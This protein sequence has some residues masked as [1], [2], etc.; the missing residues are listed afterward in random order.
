[1]I[2]KIKEIKTSRI[3][4]EL[5]KSMSSMIL[6]ETYATVWMMVGHRTVGNYYKGSGE[7]TFD[8]QNFMV[9]CKIEY[10]REVYDLLE[11]LLRTKLYELLKNQQIRRIKFI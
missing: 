10:S 1:M 8:I 11:E 5:F 4:A 7:I 3:K 6:N 2:S 9:S